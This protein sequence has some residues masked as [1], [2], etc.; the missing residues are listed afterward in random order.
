MAKLIKKKQRRGVP[1]YLIDQGGES[2][3]RKYV[4]DY[5]VER[6]MELLTVVKE[7]QAE[8]EKL[9]QLAL[10]TLESAQYL[11]TLR[12]TA[13]AERGNMQITSFDGLMQIEIITA[14]RVVL[15][16]RAIEAKYAMVEYVKKGLS[17]SKD[18]IHT[19]AVMAI[20]NDTF[21][22]TKAGCLRNG[23]VVRLL[24]Y[25]IQAREWQDACALL[26]AAMQ[27]CRGKSYL[28]VNVRSSINDT[29]EMIRLD[30]AD[31]LP[32][33]DEVQP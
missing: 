5:D 8:R 31:C 28:R 22:P 11:E 25:N 4:S 10:K 20:I 24:N 14:W 19:Q 15:D 26:R 1:A 16:D 2:I 18:D 7:W 3:P 29:F 32:T 33:S 23:M 6:Q 21:T 9:E 17:T 12:G 27:T 30:M 13:M